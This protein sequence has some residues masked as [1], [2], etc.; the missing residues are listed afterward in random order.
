M[1]KPV[2]ISS[3][4]AVRIFNNNNNNNN[5]INNNNINNNN[6]NNDDNKVYYSMKPRHNSN[7]TLSIVSCTVFKYQKS[8]Q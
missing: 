7:E 4:I 5:N 2:S 1:T 6:N 3:T 8:M